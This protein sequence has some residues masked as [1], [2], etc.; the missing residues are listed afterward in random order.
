MRGK[1]FSNCGEFRGRHV[2]VFVGEGGYYMAPVSGDHHMEQKGRGWTE[3]LR[4]LI[5]REA[6]AWDEWIEQHKTKSNEATSTAEPTES[7]VQS[8]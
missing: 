8:D 2:G 7:S 1:P 5:N 6:R 4:R 3:Q